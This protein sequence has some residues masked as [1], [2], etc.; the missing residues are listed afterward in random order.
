MAKIPAGISGDLV[1]M[2]G[3]WEHCSDLWCQQDVVL[4]KNQNVK[5]TWHPHPVAFAALL[6]C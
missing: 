5:W 2:T 6:S 1:H 4:A 3:D